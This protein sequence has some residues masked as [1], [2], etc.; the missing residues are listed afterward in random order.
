MSKPS[1]GADSDSMHRIT[2]IDSTEEN[3][4]D[5]TKAR[6]DPADRNANV[7]VG[8]GSLRHGQMRSAEEGIMV[9]NDIQVDISDDR[10]HEG[11]A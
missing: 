2:V 6:W 1:K 5:F 11:R 3:D 9:K 4:G 8:V 10:R 7:M